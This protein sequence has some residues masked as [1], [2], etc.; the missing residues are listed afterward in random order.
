MKFL[1]NLSLMASVVCFLFV[2]G[3]GAKKDS[4]NTEAAEEEMVEEATET[5]EEAVETVDSLAT[6]AV[7]SLAN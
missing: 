3:C 6:E 2:V 4:G 7:D 5:I 1:R